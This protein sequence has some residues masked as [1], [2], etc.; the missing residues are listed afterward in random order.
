[1]EFAVV[2]DQRGAVRL[3]VVASLAHAVQVLAA[4]GVRA[5]PLVRAPVGRSAAREAVRCRRRRRTAGA[6]ADLVL[7]G[8]DGLG[9]PTAALPRRTAT[10]AGARRPSTT[11][12]VRLVVLETR[13]DRVRRRHHVVAVDLTTT[14]TDCFRRLLK[15]YLFA[16]YQFTQRISGSQRLCAMQIHALTHPPTH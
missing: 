13:E 6:G 11:V 4:A 12:L 8:V 3:D 14:N 10:A 2:D 5:A 7:A 16:R 15:T 1:M 9:R